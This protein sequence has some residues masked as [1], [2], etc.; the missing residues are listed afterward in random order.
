MAK[1]LNVSNLAVV[2]V[3]GAINAVIGDQKVKIGALCLDGERLEGV[4]AELEAGALPT[5]DGENAVAV[6][7]GVQQRDAF[8]K[9][10]SDAAKKASKAKKAGGA[11]LLLLSLAACGG[12]G[13]SGTTVVAPKEASLANDGATVDISSSTAGAIVNVADSADNE[14]SQVLINGAG[15]SGTLVLDF[16]DANDTVQVV[17]A[18]EISGFTVIEVRHGTVD[19]TALG[20]GVL[21]NDTLSLGSGAIIT[22]AQYLELGAVQLRDGATSGELSIIMS[23]AEKR[24]LDTSKIEAGINLSYDIVDTAQNLLDHANAAIVSGAAAVSVTGGEAGNLL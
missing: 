2:A 14:F 10:W 13:G 16:V 4:Y 17:A 8:L 22:Y 24:A 11:S 15:S 7:A 23:V 21:S 1:D 19:F 12:G 9:K 20:L 18:S 5:A 3:D 6:P